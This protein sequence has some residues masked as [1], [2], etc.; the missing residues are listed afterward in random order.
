MQ[1]K[2]VLNAYMN[3]HASHLAANQTTQVT[4]FM[5]IW[6]CRTHTQHYQNCIASKN[7]K[8][9]TERARIEKE[10]GAR[11]TELLRLSYFDIIRF[12]VVDPMHNLFLGLAKHTVKIWKNYHF[13]V[14]LC[15]CSG[16]G[17]L[18]ETTQSWTNTKKDCIWFLLFHSWWMEK[19]HSSLFCL[20]FIWH[21]SATRLWMLVSGS[22][23]IITWQDIA[24]AHELLVQFCKKFTELYG[25]EC[26]TT[27]MPY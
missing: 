18:H 17:R 20:C 7:A 25:T 3:F 5:S 4:I 21:N 16:K 26:C 14:R 22:Q 11:Y 23:L 27:N 2:A 13:I 15:A 8:T 19:L 10:N 9:T 1:L 24:T 12:H 6:Q